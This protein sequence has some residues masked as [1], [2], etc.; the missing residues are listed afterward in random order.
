MADPSPVQS[1]ALNASNSALSTDALRESLDRVVAA[2]DFL[3]RYPYYAAILAR[4]DPVADPSVEVMAV[5]LHNHRF[6]LHINVEHLVAF[7]QYLRGILLHEVHHLVLGH[8]THPKFFGVQHPDLM[9][10]AQEV[11]ANEFIDEPLPDPLTLELFGAYGLRKV[12]STLER[13][14][15]LAA[16]RN[17]GRAVAYKHE[18]RIVDG[19]VPSQFVDTHGW[20]PGS[21][22]STPPIFGLETTRLLIAQASPDRRDHA[23]AIEAPPTLPTPFAPGTP[24]RPLLAGRTPADLL[25][26]LGGELGEPTIFVDWKTAL[27]MFVAHARAPIHTYARPSR[28][29]P[30]R[31]GQVP[32]RSYSRRNVRRPTILVAVDT[33]MSMND[34][35]LQRI[36]AQLRPMS[37]VAQLTIVECDVEIARIYPFAGSLPNV[38]GRG[39][40]DLRPVF[41]RAFLRSRRVDG[42]VYFT[43]GV[44]PFP[45]LPPEIPT[46]WMLTKPLEFSCPWGERAS[47]VSVS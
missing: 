35:E 44:G 22:S 13:Y 17:D 31:V 20:N 46:L 8:L 21:K 25:E 34:R 18:L 30:Q 2:P 16:V 42:V 39:G 27:R 11:S 1:M 43:D 15:R 38:K 37:E 12:Q 32:G 36:A 19:R 4:I 24:G 47:L 7:P 41:D 29:F 14:E 26:E 40:T 33:S 45:E 3:A 28:R 23:E 9:E 5:S 6:Y 10:I